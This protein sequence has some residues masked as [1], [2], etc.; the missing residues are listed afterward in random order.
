M[1]F[2][3]RLR[4]QYQRGVRGAEPP[5]VSVAMLLA[6]KALAIGRPLS[7]ILDFLGGCTLQY[8]RRGCLVCLILFVCLID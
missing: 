7:K 3:L 1:I 5:A 8:R 4:N 6:A 2:I